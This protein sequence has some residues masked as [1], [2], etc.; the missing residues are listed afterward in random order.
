MGNGVEVLIADSGPQ[1]VGIPAGGTAGQILTKNSDIDYD[2]VWS[3]GGGGGGAVS[4]VFGR[5][6]AITA[7]TGDYTP[8]QIGLGSV[9]NALQLQAA[10]NLNDLAS[11]TTALTNLGAGAANGLATLDGG[12]KVPL[13]QIP[14]SLIG[15]LNYQGTWNA[16]TNTPALASGI[17]T[18]GFYYKVSVAGTTSID[19]IN[20]WNVGDSIVF[21]GTTWDKIDGT[22]SEVISFNGRFG[23]V[24]SANGDYALSQISGTGQ[25]AFKAVSDNTQN[26][27]SSVKGATTVANLQSSA[28]IAGTTQDSGIAA[29]NVPLLNAVNSFTQQQYV[30]SNALTDAAPTTWNCNNQTASWTLVNTL[31]TRQLTAT[32]FHNGGRYL[33]VYRQDST[34]G[35]TFTLDPSVFVIPNDAP[36]YI[37]TAANGV[38]VLEFVGDTGKLVLN[39]APSFAIT[40]K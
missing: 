13:S 6:G 33:L 22:S 35:A 18:K 1:G 23:A 21:D 40:T 19:G 34:G 14:A 25:A 12:A 36:L 38:G 2:T 37:T 24:V 4:S 7:Q 3:T 32:N 5:T 39:A 20:N 15:G 8:T 31:G 10:N 26:T 28:D 30:A 9:A 29:A 17:G 11:R 27:V 16:T